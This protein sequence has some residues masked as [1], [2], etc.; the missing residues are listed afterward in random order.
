MENEG[1]KLIT[2]YNGGKQL[3]TLAYRSNRKQGGDALPG[4]TKRGGFLH[5][6]QCEY[7]FLTVAFDFRGIQYS[8]FLI[9]GLIDCCSKEALTNTPEPESGP[10]LILQIKHGCD[11][12]PNLMVGILGRGLFRHV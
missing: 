3:D 9:A 12:N 2:K 4:P 6:Q 8:G 7:G 10:C 11:G 5:D 1:R